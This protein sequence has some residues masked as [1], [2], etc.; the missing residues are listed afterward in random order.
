MT[1]EGA[2]KLKGHI[3]D[4]KRTGLKWREVGSTLRSYLDRVPDNPQDSTLAQLDR[5]KGWKVG[6]ARA[7]FDGGDPIPADETQPL[8]VNDRAVALMRRIAALA[9]EAAD[10]LEKG[11]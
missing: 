8:V 11:Q 2:E 7:V 3:E 4:L 5:L 9:D 10:L 1:A 6:S